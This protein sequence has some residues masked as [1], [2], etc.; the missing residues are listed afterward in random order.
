MKINGIHEIPIQTISKCEILG[1]NDVNHS[2]LIGMREL[3]LHINFIYSIILGFLYHQF[4][5]VLQ[6][7]ISFAYCI[8]TS[9]LKLHRKIYI[10]AYFQ[11]SLALLNETKS[12]N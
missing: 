7:S 4:E 11:H 10:S 1:L 2:K 8:S 5:I 9:T 3:L 12:V 6:H